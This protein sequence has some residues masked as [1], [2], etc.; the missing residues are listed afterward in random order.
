MLQGWRLGAGIGVG[1]GELLYFEGAN[2]TVSRLGVGVVV[3]GAEG[4][5][6]CCELLVAV[7]LQGAAVVGVDGGVGQAV[8]AKD[9]VDVETCPAA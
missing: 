2:Q 3:Q 1:E 4:C 8:S 5:E 9:G 7:G 6:A